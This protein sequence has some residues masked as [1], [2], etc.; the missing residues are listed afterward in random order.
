[1]IFFHFTDEGTSSERKNNVFKLSEVES[2]FEFRLC[3]SRDL[4]LLFVCLCRGKK[5]LVTI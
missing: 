4:L 2:D 5:S 1:M 3:N